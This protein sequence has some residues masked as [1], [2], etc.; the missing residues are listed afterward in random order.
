MFKAIFLTILFSSYLFSDNT[1][2]LSAANLKFFFSDII[3]Q[4]NKIYP[5]DKICVEFDSSGNIK[6]KII[7]GK[8]YDL[9]LSANKKY[10]QEVFDLNK[11]VTKPQLYTTGSL[12]LL[13]AKHK[14]LKTQNINILTHT[15]IKEITI[16][17]KKTAP[18][19]KA[20]IEALK[21]ANI[22]TKIESKLFYSTDASNIIGDVLWY[23]HAGILP[24][25]SVN[26]LPRGYNV[27]GENWVDIEQKLYKPLKQ[28]FVLS[29]QGNNNAVTKRF[30]K[31]LLNDGQKILKQNGYK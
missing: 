27:Y 18:Y 9:F 3:K 14:G 5:K 2:I 7:T 24:K 17:N 4:Y 20:A 30:I 10:A 25:S 23:G 12:V 22:F 16:A 31:F 1:T 26:F 6:K 21:N 15:S 29:N 13:I 28:Y 19:G 11:A 8:K